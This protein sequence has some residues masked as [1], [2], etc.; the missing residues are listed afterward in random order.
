VKKKKKK[1]TVAMP[2]E[3]EATTTTA[4]SPGV[5]LLLLLMML[6]LLLLRSTAAATPVGLA[7]SFAADGDDSHPLTRAHAPP[8]GFFVSSC[9]LQQPMQ[10][11]LL[12]QCP[13]LLYLPPS[14]LPSPPSP[15]FS[16]CHPN[17]LGLGRTRPSMEGLGVACAERDLA[18][19]CPHRPRGSLGSWEWW[20]W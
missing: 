16:R 13:S 17:G 19:W 11:P 3:E 1:K 4:S 8:R 5:L 10:H 7:P 2:V 18:P 12:R 15:P 9:P 14:P 20:W 6:L